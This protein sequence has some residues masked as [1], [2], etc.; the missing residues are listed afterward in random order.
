MNTRIQLLTVPSVH[1][2]I[3][4]FLARVEAL[5][6]L[7]KGNRLQRHA[8]LKRLERLCECEVNCLRSEHTLATVKRC[9]SS[10]RRALRA[11][12]PEKAALCARKNCSHERFSHLISTFLNCAIIK[13]TR[14]AERKVEELSEALERFKGLGRLSLFE[15]L[16]ARP[17]KE[18]GVQRLLSP[19]RGRAFFPGGDGVW[20]EDEER[21]LV[22]LPDQ[23][24]TF[25]GQDFD[26]EDKFGQYYDWIDLDNYHE[27]P[28]EGKASNLGATLC[29][30]WA[31]QTSRMTPVFTRTCFRE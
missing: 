27:E 23:P 1:H 24:L 21:R 17:I 9:L 29:A 2:R 11:I 28:T 3:E 20:K 4:A 15:I 7:V 16:Y 12:D 30:G 22:A 8:A 5:Y 13:M 31:A 10:Y 6:S 14:R 26:S 18:A 25:V 19:M